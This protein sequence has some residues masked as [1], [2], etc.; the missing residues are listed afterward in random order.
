MSIELS[1]DEIRVRIFQALGDPNRLEAVR[2]LWH[3]QGTE[4]T[5]SEVGELCS[6]SKPNSS[7]HFKTLREAGI[8]LVRKEGQI[9]FLRVNQDFMEKFLPGF[10]DTL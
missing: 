9:K 5:C 4:M 1:D 8:L 7:H 2:V 3:N 6:L 10:L